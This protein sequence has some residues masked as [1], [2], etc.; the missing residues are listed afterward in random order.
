MVI[1]FDA[2]LARRAPRNL[3][4]TQPTTLPADLNV[5]AGGAVQS[6]NTMALTWKAN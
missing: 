3:R 2:R 5:N 4:S 1:H 6:A